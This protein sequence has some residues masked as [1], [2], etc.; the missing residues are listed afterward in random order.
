[1]ISRL[2]RLA[3]RF[4]LLLVTMAFLTAVSLFII[5]GFLLTWP[6]LRL[7]P[8]DRKLKATADFATAGMTLLTV[9][10]DG[11]IKKMVADS[12]EPEEPEP[13]VRYPY[14]DGHAIILGPECFA[15]DDGS[16]VT[17]MG[18]QF[19][20]LNFDSVAEKLEKTDVESDPED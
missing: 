5:G 18:E 7:S 13:D 12:L 17:W 4:A 14:F 8:R 3:G 20:P 16:L 19:I 11:H 2:F 15:A 9:F 10:S 6:L 1:M